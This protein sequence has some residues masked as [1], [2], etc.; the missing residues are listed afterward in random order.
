VNIQFGARYR[1][2]VTGFEGVATA[3]AEYVHGVATVRLETLSH[4]ARTMI[5]EWITEDRLEP[6][7]AGTIR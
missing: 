2:T 6:A 1:D 4:D 7:V 5:E 3:R